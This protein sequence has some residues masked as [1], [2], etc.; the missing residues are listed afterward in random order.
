MVLAAG[1]FD[2][3]HLG[4]RRVLDCARA[5]AQR[6]GA[7]AWVLT[8]DEHPSRVLQSGSAP[9]ILTAASHKVRLL[10]EAGM[11]G[12]VMLHF[13]K[14]LAAMPASEFVQ[15]LLDAAPGLN[16][17]VVGRN[18]TFGRGGQGTAALLRRLGTRHGWVV[19]IVPPLSLDGAVVSSTRIRRLVA[20]GRL[21]AAER[22]LGRPF[23]IQGTVVVGRRQGRT[24]GVPTAN[25]DPHHEARPPHG[26]YAVLA[27]IRGRLYRAVAN[28]GVRP[29][30]GSE[31]GREPALEVHL[32]DTSLDLYG[33]EVEVFFMARLRDEWHFDSFS[34]LKAQIRRDIAHARHLLAALP[35]LKSVPLPLPKNA[36]EGFTNPCVSARVRGIRTLH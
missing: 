16:A 27:A 1:F 26:V 20:L 6:R 31:A 32:L 28:L 8:F 23:S 12:V 9:P 21:E 13:T 29:T 15:R 25:L 4:H 5:E 17:I 19:R 24:W 30:L 7:E 36:R 10:A 22:L 34:A 18:W 14:R 33:E 3:V 35:P 11:D 2:G